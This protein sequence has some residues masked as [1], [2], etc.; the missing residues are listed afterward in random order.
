[1][2]SQPGEPQPPGAVGP[3]SVPLRWMPNEDLPILYANQMILSATEG[4]G[5]ATFGRSHPPYERELSEATIARLQ[6]EGV[7]VHPVVRLA[8][9]YVRLMEISNAFRTIHEML[10]AA[11]Q[12]RSD[13]PVQEESK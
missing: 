9:P 5:I 1:M 12:P 7:E 11:S 4:L 2:A 3:I 6:E 10:T 8:I 13:K